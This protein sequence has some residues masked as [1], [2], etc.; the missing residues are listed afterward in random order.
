MAPSVKVD[1]LAK[2]MLDLALDGSEQYR[3]LEN[4][5]INELSN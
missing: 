4:S 3:I 1:A 2:M 5:N